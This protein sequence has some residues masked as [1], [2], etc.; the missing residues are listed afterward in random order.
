MRKHQVSL[1]LLCCLASV[2]FG[3]NW[4]AFSSG[5]TYHYK[6]DTATLLPDQSVHF[7][8]VDAVG[9]DSAFSVARRFLCCVDTSQRNQPMFVGRD[10][11]ATPSG[12]FS[13]RS[14]MSVHLP[15]RAG[16][17]T[18]F[19]LDSIS[20][21]TAS[22]TRVDQR[23]V[24]GFALDSVKVFT[25][26]ALDSLVL[27][28]NFGIVEWPASLG[29]RMRL[30]GIQ[31]AALGEPMPAFDGFMTMTQGADYYYESELVEGDLIEQSSQFRVRFHVDT[32]Q[33]V[34]NGIQY[35]W[36]G[37]V[38]ETERLGGS[39]VNVNVTQPSG[40]FLIEDRPKSVLKMSGHEQVRAPG[41][42]MGL[43]FPEDFATF[44]RSAG[45]DTSLR[46]WDGLWTNVTY[47]VVD[48]AKELH[49]GRNFGAVGW[50]YFGIGGDSCAPSNIDEIRATFREGMGVVHA[51]FGSFAMRGTFDMVGSIVNGDTAGTIIADEVLLAVA[52]E[53]LAGDLP[54]SISPNP[55]HDQALVQ[56]MDQG[57]GQLRV[58]DL[59]GKVL[60]QVGTRGH[61]QSLQLG[62]LP[63]G[64]YL[65]QFAQGGKSATQRLV[66]TR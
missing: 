66:V 58:M 52:E 49:Y 22:V 43:A 18:N 3:Q 23:P 42:L 54:F 27:S 33:R 12:V 30:S 31:E 2:T 41:S 63:A 26:M 29:G 59:T 11:K 39:I 50:L 6:S 35:T 9:A 14:P 37:I 48:G 55:A 62:E 28:K 56:W 36:H 34:G 45:V 1:L 44:R 16:V 32:A 51:E 10:V 21:L 19:T 53:H 61:Q 15:T 8:S 24:L 17:G 38:R 7:D 65:V 60:Q 64:M 40:T 46:V 57:A 4:M 20:G 25:T 47:E 13:F 5:R